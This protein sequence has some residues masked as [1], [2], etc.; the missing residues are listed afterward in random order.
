MKQCLP[1]KKETAHVRAALLNKNG[2]I[3]TLT[4]I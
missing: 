3:I 2:Q 4:I 1:L